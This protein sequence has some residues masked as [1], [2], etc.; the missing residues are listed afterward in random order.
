MPIRQLILEEGREV[1]AR[2][3]QKRLSAQQSFGLS[4]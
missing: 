1:S 2:G 3:Y 4:F